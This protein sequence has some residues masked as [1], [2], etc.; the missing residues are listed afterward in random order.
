MPLSAARGLLGKAKAMPGQSIPAKI[1]TFLRKAQCG[2]IKA[3]A[4]QVQV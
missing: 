2:R 4:G 3:Q 1:L